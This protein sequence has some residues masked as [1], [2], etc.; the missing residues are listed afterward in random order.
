M[1][2]T[3]LS[4]FLGAGKTTFLQH[5]LNNK[6]GKKFGLVVNDMATVNVDAKQIRQQSFGSDDGIDTMELQNGCVCCTL[7]EDMIASISK[8]VSLSD[9]KGYNYD[10]I[11]VECSGIAEPRRIRELFQQAE[12]YK[13][14][15]LQ[16]IQLDTLIT[17]VDASVFLNLF[18]TNE[19]FYANA[20]LAVKTDDTN[21]TQ[22]SLDDGS[23]QRKVTELLLEQ[24]ECADIILINKCDLLDGEDQ[25]K[26]VEKVIKSMNPTAKIVSCV[27]GAVPEPLTLMGQFGGEGAA[28]W[29][30]L[31]EH[32][33]LIQAVQQQEKELQAEEESHSHDHSHNTAAED[34][35]DPV[36]T[37]PTHKHDHSHSHEHNEVCQ[38]TTCTDPT[39]NH[40]HSHSHEHSEATTA[41]QRF[42]ISS[43]VYKRR[44]P[45]HPIR[46]TKFLQ[47]L[48]RLSVDGVVQM[49]PASSSTSAASSSELN[50]ATKSLLRSKGFVWMATSGAAAYFMS[51]AG[52]Y[53]DLVVLGRWWADIDR[54]EWPAGLEEEITLDF[55]PEPNS[56]H[57]DRR[58]EL[59]FIGQFEGGDSKGSGAVN[60][61]KAMEAVLDSCLLTDEEML[62]YEKVS[63][64]GDAA[65]REYFVPP[66]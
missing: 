64:K 65:L 63:K 4:G 11:I 8:L 37:D 62:T 14:G 48:G 29:G 25:I 33:Q 53:L 66:K 45:F 24:V 50:K 7:A 3:V 16:K 21:W 58:Q 32:R 34:C 40:D 30:V 2:I 49:I 23:G 12:D 54:K 28:S 10:H 9:L 38:D 31:D 52:Q 27:R 46:F 26:L 55:D 36:C 15:M 35:K 6:E 42:G 59:V 51:H 56:L 57:G 44:R 5:V 22:S 19:D 1:P 39:H 20:A 13:M 60:S 47:G 18:G 61:R 41:A 43:F 17:L